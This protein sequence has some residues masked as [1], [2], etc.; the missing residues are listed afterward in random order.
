MGSGRQL[1][2]WHVASGVVGLVL[3]VYL[4]CRMGEG[5]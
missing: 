4:G 2:W 3:W 1:I 5:L